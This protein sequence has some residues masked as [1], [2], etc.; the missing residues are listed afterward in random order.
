MND[1]TD[2]ATAGFRSIFHRNGRFGYADEIYP[3]EGPPGS[4][5]E[6]VYQGFALASPTQKRGAERVYREKNQV[7][8]VSTLHAPVHHPLNNRHALVT[9][10]NALAER[11]SLLGERRD[12][13]GSPCPCGLKRKRNGILLARGAV[14]L[15]PCA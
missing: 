2:M 4:R 12:L 5:L 9:F 8:I 10:L 14:Q 11:P 7:Y 6:K 3:E 13:S 15:R 1:T